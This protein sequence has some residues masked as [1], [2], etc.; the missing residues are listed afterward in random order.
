MLTSDKVVRWVKKDNNNDVVLLEW[1]LIEKLSVNGKRHHITTANEDL[2][3][4]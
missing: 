3:F 2:K 1:S 4:E